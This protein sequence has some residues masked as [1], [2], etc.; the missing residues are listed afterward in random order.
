MQQYDM[1]TL[2]LSTFILI[3]GEVD[4]RTKGI[5]GWLCIVGELMVVIRETL[6]VILWL[7]KREKDGGRRENRENLPFF[8]FVKPFVG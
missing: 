7:P 6:V 4:I 8:F 5:G 1:A 2:H 3:P